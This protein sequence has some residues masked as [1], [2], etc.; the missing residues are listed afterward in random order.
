MAD[1][2]QNSKTLE[3]QRNTIHPRHWEE[4]GATENPNSDLI[5]QNSR[6][7]EQNFTLG[8]ASRSTWV[9][10][11]RKN[12]KRQG[13]EKLDDSVS[14]KLRRFPF[15]FLWSRR[16][17]M[18]VVCHKESQRHLATEFDRSATDRG[19]TSC[20]SIFALSRCLPRLSGHFTSQNGEWTTQS[21]LFNL[22]WKH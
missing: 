21:H 20:P 12:K 1:A 22:L 8:R 16:K 6:A 2:L 17:E 15:L 7:P 10:E 4:K 18:K 11:R 3:I 5:M 13:K 9:A 19:P 14:R